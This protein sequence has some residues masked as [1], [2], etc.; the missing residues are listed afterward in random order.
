MNEKIRYYFPMAA[1]PLVSAIIPSFNRFDLLVKCV[2]SVQNQSHNDIEIIV[3]DDCSTD[4]R[5]LTLGQLFEGDERVQILRLEE[6]QRAKHKCKAAQGMTRNHGLEIAKG[7]YIAFLD[8]DDLWFPNK[9][10]LQLRVFAQHPDCLLVATNTIN[11]RNAGG[12]H[13]CSGR[14]MHNFPRMPGLRIDERLKRIGRRELLKQNF[15]PNSSVVIHRSMYEKAGA[16]VLGKHQDY[17]YWKRVLQH[18]DG[19]FLNIPTVH[20]D[21]R[22][23]KFYS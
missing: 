10:E 20:Y 7:D 23:Q 4:E 11:C 13:I 3:V 8:D 6:N 17:E 14:L 18:T 21:T 2:G 9:I 12:K 22:S 19:L 1:I 15:F 16:Q 5:Y